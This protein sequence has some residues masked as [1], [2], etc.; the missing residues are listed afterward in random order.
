[1]TKKE[2]KKLL[3]VKTDADLAR[4]LNITSQAVARWGEQDADI[5]EQRRWQIEAMLAN[6]GRKR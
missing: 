1:M 3:G 4:K 2:A 6:K 5:P